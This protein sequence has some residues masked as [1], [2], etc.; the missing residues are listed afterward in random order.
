MAKTDKKVKVKVANRRSL[1]HD[2]KLHGPGEIVELPADEALD[3]RAKGFVEDLADDSQPAVPR[4]L[5]RT[6]ASKAANSNTAAGSGDGGTG[7]GGSAGG[8][9]DDAGSGNGDQQADGQE[10]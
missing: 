2:G 3:L 1:D 8:A 6:S 5:A 9:G 7:D 4:P 10:Q